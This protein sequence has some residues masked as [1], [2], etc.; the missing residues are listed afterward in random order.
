VK[1]IVPDCLRQEENMYLV[2][3][4]D[5]AMMRHETQESR[6]FYN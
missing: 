1:F 2:V 3:P 6:L 5:I 4:P